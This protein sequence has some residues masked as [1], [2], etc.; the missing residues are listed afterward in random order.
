MSEATFTP[1]FVQADRNARGRLV[2]KGTLKKGLKIG[3]DVHRDF[4]LQEAN[5]GD[6]MDA[7]MNADITKPLNY[8]MALM[9]KQLARIGT[10][11][12]PFTP[13]L[14]RGLSQQ[15][16]RTLRDAQAELDLMGELA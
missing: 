2:A 14:L 11:E 7:E 10:F 16:L 9:A 13:G 12:G 3:E 8:S 1:V 4:E 15:D 6:L 5:A